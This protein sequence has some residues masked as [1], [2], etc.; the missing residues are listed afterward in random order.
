LFIAGNAVDRVKKKS[1]K[2]LLSIAKSIDFTG[3]AAIA[4][5]CCRYRI[6]SYSFMYIEWFI[7]F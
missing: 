6:A 2:Q 7:G 3:V 1:G 4:S 5:V